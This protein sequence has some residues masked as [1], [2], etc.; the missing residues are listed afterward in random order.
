MITEQSS[1]LERNTTGVNVFDQLAED[2]RLKFLDDQR[3][4]SVGRRLHGAKSQI[5]LFLKKNSSKTTS[6]ETKI[7]FNE[8]QTN[9][10]QGDTRH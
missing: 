3:L 9:P 6:N 8:K 2:I 4:M 7:S 10:C 5:V 1:R